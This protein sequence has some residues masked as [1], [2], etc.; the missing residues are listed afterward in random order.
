M[1]STLKIPICV[2]DMNC[3]KILVCV[4]N[5]NNKKILVSGL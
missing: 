1:K 4:C 3:M 5:R 2:Y